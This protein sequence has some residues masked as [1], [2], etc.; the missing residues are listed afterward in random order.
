MDAK[1]LSMFRMIY[2]CYA[3]VNIPSRA[4]RT[5]G[6]PAER[7]DPPPGIAS[8]LPSFPSYTLVLVLN[9]AVIASLFCLAIGF[10]TR[11][12]SLLVVALGLV[13]NAW[14]YSLGKID[15]EL[16]FYIAPL[17]LAF[18]GWGR[19]YSLDAKREN[20]ES[21]GKSDIQSARC[22]ALF[23][24]ACGLGFATAGLAK[25][26]SGW[27]SPDQPAALGHLAKYYYFQER[28]TVLA[29]YLMDHGSQFFWELNDW[30]TV[31]FEIGF[32]LAV[33]HRFAFQLFLVLAVIFH[34]GVWLLMSIDFTQNLIAYA[35]FVPWLLLLPRAGAIGQAKAS[36]TISVAALVFFLLLSVAA[37]VVLVTQESRILAFAST[38]VAVILFTI[39]IG[40]V[41]GWLIYAIFRLISGFKDL[42]LLQVGNVPSDTPIIY[43]DGH[44]GLCNTWV[45]E[46]LKRDH[47]RTFRFAPLQGETAKRN[48]GD[49]AR[50]DNPD[51]II[52]Q[53]QSGTY[54]RSTAVLRVMSQL[55][56]LAGLAK[57]LLLIPMPIRDAGYAAVAKHRLRF[58]GGHKQACRMPT[59]KEIGVILP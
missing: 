34:L 18:S 40:F 44:C 7:F 25:A 13:L 4:Y 52:L 47:S 43:F 28:H 33:I 22:I 19:H 14:H 56:R 45:D 23:A 58:F 17:F 49:S 37:M 59:E 8:L 30:L 35:V 16:M 38:P 55:P 12:A 57:V 39:G 42:S 5:L 48:F 32:L 53:D 54:Q 24:L 46:V 36:A 26:Y 15:H 27:L 20:Q 3:L 31:L 50:P 1:S 11:T 41:L 6:Q 21:L 29:G 9:L 2:C 10:K 51:T